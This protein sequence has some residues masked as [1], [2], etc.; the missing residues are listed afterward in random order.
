M[1]MTSKQ[2]ML[3]AL[4]GGVPDRLPVTTHFLMP[5]FLNTCMG[6]MSEAEFF[7][8]CGW[9]PIMYTV[10]HRPDPDRGE[11]YDPEQGEPG[12]LESRRIATDDWRVEC[13]AIPGHEHPTTRYRFVTPK[14]AL[15]MVLQADPF[16]AW[17][18]EPL[19]KQKRDIDLIGEYVTA[20]KCDVQAVN[21]AA[22]ALGQRG[23]VRGYICCFDVFG[24]PGTWQDATCLVGIERLIMETYDDPAWVHELLRI[25]FR[26][27]LIGGEDR[28]HHTALL[29]GI[30]KPCNVN[31][32]HHKC[33]YHIHEEVMIQP[34]GWE[35]HN[36]C[37]PSS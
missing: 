34:D 30:R 3:I 2:R 36:A 21:R 31:M 18:V 16:T 19:V 15:T 7:D 1:S 20:P 8:T 11:Y 35:Q 23:L 10:P 12:F 28:S 32:D 9:D 17:V 4:D 22:E 14:G 13:E 6:G 5:H 27:E 33:E 25:L 24:Q 37:Q 29:S 26:Y